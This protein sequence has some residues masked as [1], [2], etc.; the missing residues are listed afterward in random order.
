MEVLVSL[1]VA[2]LFLAFLL[3]GSAAAL[4]RMQLASL[5]TEALQLAR[6]QVEL[7]SAWPAAEPVPNSGAVGSLTWVVKQTA[8]DGAQ[9]TSPAAATLR[10]FRVTVTASGEQA[11]L[12]DMT[13]HRLGRSP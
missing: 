11:P 13:V 1:A 3:P 6:N 2:A 7:L 10:T 8:I 9:S 4:Q 12:V 5:Q